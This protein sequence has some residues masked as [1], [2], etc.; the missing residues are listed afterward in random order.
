[1][2]AVCACVH[3]NMLM[4]VLMC[5]YEEDRIVDIFPNVPHLTL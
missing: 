1:M 5:A 4:C 3:M 2:I